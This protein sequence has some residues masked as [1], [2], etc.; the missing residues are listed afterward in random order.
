VLLH[1]SAHGFTAL[2]DDVQLAA[3]ELVTNAMRH[4]P[5]PLTMILR[6]H[7]ETVRLDVIDGWQTQPVLVAAT[8]M[9]AQGR[10][11][12]IVDA[13]SHRWGVTDLGVDGKSVWAEFD[14]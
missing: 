7:D 1:L 3:S 12:A 2:V 6:G 5:P 14:A 4:A 8:T 9:D 11:V 10:G 13:L